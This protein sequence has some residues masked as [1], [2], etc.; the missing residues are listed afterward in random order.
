MNLD[1]I[2]AIISMVL[3]NLKMNNIITQSSSDLGLGMDK[4]FT[5]SVIQLEYFL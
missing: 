4:V 1:I 5:S 3:L 2:I